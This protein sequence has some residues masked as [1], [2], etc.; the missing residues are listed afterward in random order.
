VIDVNGWSFVKGD[1]SYYDKAAKNIVAICEE[2]KSSN[3][4]PTSTL[5]LVSQCNNGKRHQMVQ[6]SGVA[7]SQAR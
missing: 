3:G 5:A 6:T 4:D 2:A 7:T 1:E